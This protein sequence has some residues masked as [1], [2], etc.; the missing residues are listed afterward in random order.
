MRLGKFSIVDAVFVVSAFLIGFAF[1]AS[2][3]A[4]DAPANI[5]VLSAQ[6]D[7]KSDVEIVPIVEEEPVAVNEPVSVW[8]IAL[9]AATVGLAVSVGW[10]WPKYP[11]NNLIEKTDI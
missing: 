3:S 4:P 2:F 9:A 7:V 10:F 5:A 1:F 8:L 11:V 6:T